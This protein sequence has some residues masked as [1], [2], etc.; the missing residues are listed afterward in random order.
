M[1]NPVQV[2]FRDMASS[3]AIREACL[4]EVDKLERFHDRLTS[5]RI[6][7]AS[8]HRHHH[9]GVLYS[10]RVDLTLPGREIV[11]NRDHHED[12]SHE[13]VYVAIR[14][15]FRAT[16][17]QLEDFSHK[18]RGDVKTHDEPALGR[19]DR[20]FPNEDY[21]FIQTKDGRELYFHKNSLLNAGFEEVEVGN[22]VRFVEENGDE[23]PQ[24][25][26]IRVVGRS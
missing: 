18:R 11:V 4:K 6:V 17:R 23:G 20:I 3:D 12:H 13:D 8:P 2:T 22:E 14:D 5:M 21:G 26:S 16:R 10:I 15:A 9:K 7:V 1:Q 24:A 19:V 25:S